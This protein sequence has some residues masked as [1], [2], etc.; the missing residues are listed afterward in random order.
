VYTTRKKA[1]G[2]F[3]REL[4]DLATK[5]EVLA[6]QA[7]KIGFLFH[8]LG[9]VGSRAMVERYVRPVELHRPAPA[10]IAEASAAPTR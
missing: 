7:A 9:V 10:A 6:A 5:D 3:K 4:W 1:I 2:P 8:E